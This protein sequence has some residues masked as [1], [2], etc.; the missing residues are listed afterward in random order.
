V[1]SGRASATAR[2]TTPRM[3]LQAITRRQRAPVHRARC[4][5][6]QSIARH[7]TVQSEVRSSGRRS[8]MHSEAAGCSGRTRAAARDNQAQRPLQRAQL[9]PSRRIS[10]PPEKTFNNAAASPSARCRS[11]SVGT[12]VRSSRCRLVAQLDKLGHTVTL[13]PATSTATSG[14]LHDGISL[15]ILGH[16]RL[17]SHAR[18]S[19][20]A[21]GAW[22]LE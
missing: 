21:E 2:E 13:E 19:G 10:P 3:P 11:A 17:N 6:R 5:G 12:A 9:R 1:V 7:D 15:S 22:G 20:H 4:A 18:E 14:P 16:S 8:P